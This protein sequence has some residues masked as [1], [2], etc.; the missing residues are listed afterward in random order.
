M[1]CVLLEKKTVENIKPIKIVV[2]CRDF[3][4]LFVFCCFCSIVEIEIHGCIML[5]IAC[6]GSTPGIYWVS[7][8]IGIDLVDGESKKWISHPG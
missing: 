2:R 5:Y 1:K 6:I 8:V 7:R 3:D 4:H